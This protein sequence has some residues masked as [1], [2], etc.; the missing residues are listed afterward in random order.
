M[1]K[2]LTTHQVEG[3]EQGFDYVQDVSVI[4]PKELLLVANKISIKKGEGSAICHVD[5]KQ[6]LSP[7]CIF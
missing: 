2:G 7:C 6:I 3:L 4:E 5:G 1:A